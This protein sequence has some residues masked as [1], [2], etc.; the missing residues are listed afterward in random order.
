M[1][2]LLR[3]ITVLVAVIIVVIVGLATFIHFYL[4][5]DRLK[6]LIIPPAERTLGRKIDVGNIKAGLFSGIV[7]R[8]VIIKEADGKADFARLRTFVLRYSLL[9]LLHKNLEVNT[10][11]IDSPFVRLIR[12]KD[13]HFNYETLKFLSR[14]PRP[15]TRVQRPARPS[16]PPAAEALPLFLTV[17]RI[18][19]KDAKVELLD[20]SGEIPKTEAKADMKLSLKIGRDISSMKYDGELIFSVTSKYGNLNPLISG[21]SKFN[22]Q[23]VDFSVDLLTD[24]QRVSLTGQARNYLKAPNIKLDITSDEI[25]LDRLLATAASLPSAKGK[26]TVARSTQGREGSTSTDTGMANPIQVN[27]N[28]AFR[29]ILYSGIEIKNLKGTYQ[30][31]DQRL[32]IRDISTQ[33][34]DGTIN[35]TLTI[36]L[37]KAEPGYQ[38]NLLI[39]GVNLGKIVSDLSTTRRLGRI[40]AIAGL[41]LTFSGAGSTWPVMRETLSAIGNYHLKDVEIGETPITR[42]ISLLLGLKELGILR[43]DTIDGNL[44]IHRGDVLVKAKMSGNDVSAS[45]DGKVGLDGRLDMPLTITLGPK[46]TKKLKSRA[47]ITRYLMTEN[48]QAVV[49]LRLAGT[50]SKPAPRLNT[51]AIKEKAEKEIRQRAFQALEKVLDKKSSQKG[52]S[53]NDTGNERMPAGKLLKGLFG[54]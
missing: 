7:V 14:S 13:G 5:E 10:I 21:N 8:D 28:L 35:S 45:A 24:G 43:F 25:D 26:K 52:Q 42:A 23:V 33:V 9:P 54:R 49:S 50:I 32:V 34:A 22:Q 48:G 2:R 3:I 27:G 44:K 31:K 36:D 53:S 6:A 20:K 39:K 11:V 37:N 17:D 30:F 29:K 16:S 18:H 38:G 46:L 47:S 41:N 4:T 40:S 12:E 15:G 51:A 19:V 1:G